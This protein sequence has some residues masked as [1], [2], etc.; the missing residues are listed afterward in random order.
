MYNSFS[1]LIVMRLQDVNVSF[2]TVIFPSPVSFSVSEAGLCSC[3][4][5]E[6]IT[7]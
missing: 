3:S 6:V 7:L 4:C 5:S 1:L 2:Q